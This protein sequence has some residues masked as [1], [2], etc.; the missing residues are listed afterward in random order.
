[1]IVQMALGG[2]TNAIIHLIAMARRAGVALD[3]RRLRRDLAPGAGARQH[4][5]LGQNT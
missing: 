1:M 5:P 2:S 3:A 4:P